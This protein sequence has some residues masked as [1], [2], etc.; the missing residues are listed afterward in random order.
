[1]LPHQKALQQ[2]DTILSKWKG[3]SDQVH[4]VRTLKGYA[5]ERLGRTEEA[6]EVRLSNMI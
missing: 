2:A 1:M 6:I 3:P 5:L 4:L